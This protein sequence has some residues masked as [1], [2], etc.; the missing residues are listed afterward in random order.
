MTTLIGEKY[1]KHTLNQNIKN[2]QLIY[3]EKDR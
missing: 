1:F 3:Q 2:D